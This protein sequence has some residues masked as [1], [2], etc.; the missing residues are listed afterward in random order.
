M[1]RMLLTAALVC[2]VT[3]PVFAQVETVTCGDYSAMDNAEQIETV[4]ELESLT[5]EMA[6]EDELTADAIHEKLAA[7]LQGQGR[8]AGH[9]RGQ[10]E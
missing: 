3:G 6:K 4:A 2:G 8:H 5:S 7:R 10:G 1:K 9:R